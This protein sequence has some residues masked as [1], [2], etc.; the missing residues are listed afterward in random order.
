[1]DLL[2]QGIVGA[3]MAQ[4]TRTHRAHIAGATACGFIG[5][6]APDLDAL[7]RS[8]SDPLIFLEYH[9]HFTHALAFIPFGGLVCGAALYLAI[10]KRLQ[11]SFWQTVAF[12]TLG[13]ATHGL[14]DAMTSYGT[15]LLW[16]FSDTRIS[17]SLVSIIDPV[18]TVPAALLILAAW[19]KRR[20]LFARLALGWMAI[21]LGAAAFQHTHALNAAKEIAEA[22]GDTPLRVEVKPSFGNILVWRSIYETDT[23]F[24]IDAMRVGVTR[25]MFE[26]IRVPKV[27]AAVDFP[28]LK[29]DSQQARDVERFRFFSRGYIARDPR[30]PNRIIDI[31]YAFVPNSLDAL[32][33][34]E[35]SPDVPV[36]AH[37]TYLTHRE[38]ARASLGRL[39]RMIVGN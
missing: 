16:P 17:W 31:R 32:W 19:I 15:S 2:T 35:V 24:Y 34:V 25:R 22:R 30:F 39:W 7:I 18:F 12:C 38:E 27:E 28:W 11:L 3:A 23:A 20:V 26:G 29:P 4:A 33:S 9:R 21:Y 8:P 13:Y 37:V 10:G 36:D 1:M 5:G 14:L 6:L